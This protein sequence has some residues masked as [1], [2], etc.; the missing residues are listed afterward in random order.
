MIVGHLDLNISRSHLKKKLVLYFSRLT[1]HSPM[2]ETHLRPMAIKEV[3]VCLS[4]NL[5][6]FK[7]NSK[8]ISKSMDRENEILCLVS[9]TIALTA[10]SD[11]FCTVKLIYCNPYLHSESADCYIVDLHRGSSARLPPDRIPHRQHQCP[12]SGKLTLGSSLWLAWFLS[13]HIL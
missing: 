13:L 11:C 7:S 8:Q 10:K 5:M 2:G 4:F 9:Q 12:S 3:S 6:R 1:N